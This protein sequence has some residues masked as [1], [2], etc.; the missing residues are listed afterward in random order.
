MVVSSLPAAATTTRIVDSVQGTLR[1]AI[2]RGVLRSGEPLSVP[3]LSRKLNVSRSPVREAV[4]GLVAEGLAIEQPR[5]GVM[6]ASVEAKDL[7]QIHEIRVYLEAGAARLC[8][9]RINANGTVNLK[10]IL[11]KQ[12]VAV[13]AGDSEGYFATNHE[14]HR[15]IAEGACNDRMAAMLTLLEGQMRIALHQ[16]V[17]SRKHMKQ[18][19]LEHTQIVEAIAAKQPGQAERSMRDH[20]A[21]TIRRL[22]AAGPLVAK[23]AK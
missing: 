21:S 10:R 16:V 22:E 8:A 1:D 13:T 11:R 3:E 20:I 18:G 19:L 15:A 6:V 2:L 23:A 5:K 12:N 7:L 9:E 4:L 17:Q 14:L